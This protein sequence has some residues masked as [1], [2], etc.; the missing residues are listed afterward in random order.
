MRAGPGRAPSPGQSAARAGSRDPQAGEGAR[1]PA[2]VPQPPHPAQAPIP[3]GTK[4]PKPAPS[5]PSPGRVR[6]PS[7]PSLRRPTVRLSLSPSVS[8]LAPYP[9]PLSLSLQVLALCLSVPPNL[10]VLSLS[11]TSALFTGSLCPPSS[12]LFPLLC[13]SVSCPPFLPPFCLP[14]PV[15]HPCFSVPHLSHALALCP[16]SFC[17]ARF[18]S[19]LCH[20]PPS[21]RPPP[22]TV[23]LSPGPLPLPS[24]PLQPPS[25]DPPPFLHF[26]IPLSLCAP[27]RN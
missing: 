13:P 5:P 27:E 1:A 10:S 3:A 25:W 14:L 11:P 9:C 18:S 20:L 24:L 17:H 8:L 23:C 19:P 26:S 15:C 21:S 16:L 6:R 2:A 4:G 7:V 22:T 12:S